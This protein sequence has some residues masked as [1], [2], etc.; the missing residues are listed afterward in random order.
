MAEGA[1]EDVARSQGIHGVDRHHRYLAGRALGV[2][3]DRVAVT[4][5]GNVANAELAQPADDPCGIAHARW[6]KIVGAHRIINQGQQLVQPLLPTAAVEH[7]RDAQRLGPC[8]QLNRLG[9]IVAVEHEN[10]GIFEQRFVDRFVP[11]FAQIGVGVDHAAVAVGQIHH[12]RGQDR[13]PFGLV[14]TIDQV[15]LVF[16]DIVAGRVGQG[17]LAQAGHQRS[18]VAEGGKGDGGIGGRPA[19][20]GELPLGSQ[21]LISVQVMGNVINY[22]GRCQAEKDAFMHDWNG[23]VGKESG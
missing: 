3:E 20:K 12:D 5:D 16:E 11:Q 23:S 21:F 19:G 1:V 2:G 8:G 14:G 15:H 7:H 17:V 10:I 9:Q 6:E 13:R 4:G 18:L 22:I